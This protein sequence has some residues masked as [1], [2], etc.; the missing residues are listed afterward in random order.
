MLTIGEEAREMLAVTALRI[1]GG[2]LLVHTRAAVGAGF[3]CFI[4]PGEGVETLSS[5]LDVRAF[6]TIVQAIFKAVHK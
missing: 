3:P 5:R 1:T 2:A 4:S 6:K